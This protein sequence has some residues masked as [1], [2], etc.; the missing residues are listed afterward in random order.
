M[1]FISSYVMQDS[2]ATL[3]RRPVSKRPVPWRD[4]PPC[5]Q[6]LVDKCPHL[7]RQMTARRIDRADRGAVERMTV[8]YRQQPP[9]AQI[10]ADQ[11]GRE[12]RN[13][14]SRQRGVA[15]GFRV[16]RAEAAVDRDRT[17]LLVDS[18]AP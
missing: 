10:V 6:Q 17:R 18:E 8:E 1:F 4:R 11:E 16:G 12:P 7:R 9:G 15:Q 13:A 2:S 14:E 3:P 5:A